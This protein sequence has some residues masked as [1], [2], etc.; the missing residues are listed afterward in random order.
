MPTPHTPIHSG[1]D[2]MTASKTEGELRMNLLFI[3]PAVPHV[4]TRRVVD[5]VLWR[6]S[7]LVYPPRCNSGS[8]AYCSAHC[9][10]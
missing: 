7:A 4:K 8:G 2:G 10:G 1:F 5:S 3:I 6:E 9:I